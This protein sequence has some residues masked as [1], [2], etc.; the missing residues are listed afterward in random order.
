MLLHPHATKRGASL[1]RVTIRVPRDPGVVHLEPIQLHDCLPD[2]P[3]P[4]RE[5]D[6]N[7]MLK[8]QPLLNRVYENGRYA[9]RVDYHHDPLP[10]LE[11]NDAA[12]A[13]QLLR[14]AQ[15]R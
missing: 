5:H 14:A 12:W 6:A 10:P 2:L 3:I 1:Y 7:V 4:L 8:L 13:D 11:S 15:R 9:I